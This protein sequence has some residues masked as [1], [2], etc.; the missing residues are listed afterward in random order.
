MALI[1]PVLEYTV[2]PAPISTLPLKVDPEDTTI[3]LK[4]PI[5]TK[6]E[7]VTTPEIL[8]APRT[9]KGSVGFVVPT[10]TLESVLIPV[11]TSI[12]LPPLKLK[13]DPSPK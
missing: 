7:A 6:R 9:V 8:A 2:A 13:V 1:I 3:S 4:L 10:P 11:L 5:P 12:Q